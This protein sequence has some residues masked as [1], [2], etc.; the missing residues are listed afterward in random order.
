MQSSATEPGSTTAFHIIV[1]NSKA[2][3]TQHEPS[4]SYYLGADQLRVQGDAC[5][6]TT[7]PARHNKHVVGGEIPKTYKQ[8]T[9]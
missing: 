4:Q 2:G 8:I 7:L 6:Q 1:R 3:G 5:H 9:C